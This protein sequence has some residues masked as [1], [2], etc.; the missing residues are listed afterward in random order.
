ML[1]AKISPA[2][3][4]ITDSNPFAPVTVSADYMAAIARPY[5][6]GATQVNFQV[7][8]GTLTPA[9]GETPA[10]FNGLLNSSVTLSG[11]Q[12]ESWGIDDSVILD[13]I[14]TTYG[15]DVLETITIPGEMF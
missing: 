8:F 1:I 4:V 2:A 12:L 3:Q 9:D 7:V 5:T 15:A 6:L 11:A 10:K 14:A 13:E